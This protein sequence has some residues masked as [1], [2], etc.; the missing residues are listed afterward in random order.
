MNTKLGMV[1][2][3]ALAHV[4]TLVAVMSFAQG[5]NDSITA[6]FEDMNIP[7]VEKKFVSR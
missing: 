4:L 1:R 7:L 2:K 5:V 6:M 3:I